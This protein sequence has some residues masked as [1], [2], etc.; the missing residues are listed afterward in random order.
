MTLYKELAIGPNEYRIVVIDKTSK[1]ER[2]SERES[3]SGEEE[4]VEKP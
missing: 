4:R 2:E 1:E 3:G